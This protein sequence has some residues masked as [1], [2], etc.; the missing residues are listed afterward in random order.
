MIMVH[1]ARLE[2][3]AVTGAVNAAES[4]PATLPPASAPSALQQAKERRPSAELGTH[5]S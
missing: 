3:E 5:Q 2:S 4:S 1:M